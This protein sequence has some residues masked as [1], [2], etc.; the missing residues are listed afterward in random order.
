M[1]KKFS[2]LLLA[3][4]LAPA[5][6]LAQD[7]LEQGEYICN[8]TPGIL[9]CSPV[10]LFIGPGNAWKWGKRTGTWSLNGSDIRFQGPKR[11][12]VVW[13]SAHLEGDQI[14]WVDGKN[15]MTFKLS[16]PIKR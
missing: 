10:H 8:K 7:Q 13:G 4:A 16:G 15:S 12:P 1:S 6:A 2:V 9:P 11:G 3:L 5:A 14:R